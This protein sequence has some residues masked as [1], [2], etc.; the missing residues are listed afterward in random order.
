[1]KHVFRFA[2]AHR[3]LWLAA[4][5]AALGAMLPGTAEAAEPAACHDVRMADPGWSDID[6]TNAVAGVVLDALG[7]RQQVSNLSVPI[8]YQ[9]LKKGSSPETVEDLRAIA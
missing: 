8:T 5:P 9:G 3:A 6:A 4:L 2:R 1:M 7:Y